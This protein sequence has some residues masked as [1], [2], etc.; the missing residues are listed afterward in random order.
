VG[1]KPTD[2]KE[3]ADT[4]E[5]QHADTARIGVA[6]GSSRIAS[7]IASQDRFTALGVLGHKVGETGG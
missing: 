4:F 3:R 5:R 6:G 1:G 7:R 2:A